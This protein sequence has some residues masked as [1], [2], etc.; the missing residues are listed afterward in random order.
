[1]RRGLKRLVETLPTEAR[2]LCNPC[3]SLSACHFTERSDEDRGLTGLESSVNEFG[4]RVVAVEITRGVE[5]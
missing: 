4:D 5:G 3:H 2:S 1:M